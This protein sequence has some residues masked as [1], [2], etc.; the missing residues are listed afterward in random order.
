NLDAQPE[1]AFSF[2]LS[3]RVPTAWENEREPWSP[4]W[5]R[6]PHL[7][8]E[9]LPAQDNK[10]QAQRSAPV[11]LS[12]RLFAAADI[13][14]SRDRDHG[15]CRGKSRRSCRFGLRSDNLAS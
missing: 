5:S 8:A 14:E 11:G 1:R 13:R 15:R 9:P 4:F 7:R 6:P 2:H 10:G 3:L 12:T